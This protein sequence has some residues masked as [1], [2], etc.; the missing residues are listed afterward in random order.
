MPTLEVRDWD[1]KGRHT[2]TERELIR[3]PSGASILPRWMRLP[4]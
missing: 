4:S 3:L 1:S 2:T